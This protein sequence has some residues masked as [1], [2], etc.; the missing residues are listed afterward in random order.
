MRLVVENFGPVVKADVEILPFTVFIGKNNTGKSTLSQLVYLLRRVFTDD[1]PIAI[2]CTVAKTVERKSAKEALAHLTEVDVAELSKCI[3]FRKTL[4]RFFGV[5]LRKL[6]NIHA[7]YAVV[8]WHDE[9]VDLRLRIEKDKVE[10]EEL[11]PTE[12]LIRRMATDVL[13]MVAT[14]VSMGTHLHARSNFY[15]PG[16]RAGLLDSYRMWQRSYMQL[17]PAVVGEFYDIL[18]A[19][20]GHAG[21]LADVAKLFLDVIEGDVAIE[22][23]SKFVYRRNGLEVDLRHA[24]SLVKELAPLYLI[25]RELVK[26]GDFMAV[27]EPEAHLHPEAQ[28]RLVDVFARLVEAGVTMLV[29]TQSETFL[30]RL[31]HLLQG[32][33]R[34]KAKVYLFKWGEEGSVVEPADITRG[35]P[36]FDEVFQMLYRESIK[37]AYRRKRRKNSDK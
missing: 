5:E 31:S 6:I 11:K 19:L 26:S 36:T 37:L 20:E 1:L 12:E 22:W 23:P 3:N 13:A 35:V 16:G 21:P 33:L 29:T 10:V 8:E 27:E 2:F 9:N 28:V 14:I 25:V 24:A 7:D 32:P 30:W 17:V 15:I 4:E 34:D 18:D